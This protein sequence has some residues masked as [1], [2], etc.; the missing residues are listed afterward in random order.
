MSGCEWV[1]YQTATIIIVFIISVATVDL[2]DDVV[3][4]VVKSIDAGVYVHVH[5]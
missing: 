5:V 2:L 3:L 1:V 4:A